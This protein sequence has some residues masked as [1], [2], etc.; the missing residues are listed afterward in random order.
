MPW[1][2]PGDVE[3]PPDP[4]LDPVRDR[5]GILQGD[6]PADGAYVL[7]RAETHWP[8]SGGHLWWSRWAA[9]REA[10]HAYLRS[11]DGRST[12]WV[13]SDAELEAAVLDWLRGMFRHASRSYT[14]RW[15][16]EDDAARI[17]NEVFTRQ[18]R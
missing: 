8:R 16:D 9:P 14:V 3:A 4:A 5:V 1:S 13:V 17:R 18:A 15:Q 2:P 11:A 10:I 6:G 12:E 7:L